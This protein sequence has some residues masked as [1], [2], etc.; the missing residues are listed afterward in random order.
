MRKVLPIFCVAG[1]I[2]AVACGG[3]GSSEFVDPG[4]SGGDP[5][6]SGG[7]FGG[8]SSGGT[9]G[10]SVDGAGFADATDCDA[11]PA[12]CLPPAV[13]GDGKAGLGESC[14]DGNIV[15]G[16][17]CSSTCKIEGP[18]WACVFGSLCIDVRDCGDGGAEAGTDGGCVP[19]PK[20]PACGDG[21]I[22]PGEACD[23]GNLAGG[24]GCAFDCK[25]IEPNFVCPTPGA[26]CQSTVVCGDNKISGSETCDDGNMASNDGC[27]ASCQ[28]ENGWTCPLPGVACVAKQC[29][30]GLVAG[31]EECDDGNAANGDGCSSTCKL[32]TQVVTVAPTTTTPGSTNIVHYVC[33]YPNP[34]L[35]PV[36]QVCTTTVCGNG[37]R[38]GSEQCDDGN[39]SPY[40]G[41]S[42]SCEFEPSCPGGACVAKCGDGLVFP[43][44]ACDDGNTKNGDGCSSAC[45]IE[46]GYQCNVQV[47]PD[48]AFLDIPIVLRDFKHWSSSDPVSHPD[49]E[50]YGCAVASK[51]LVQ[52]ML[53][54]N[55]V[56]VF[57][58]NVAVPANTC[59]TQLTSATDFTDWYRDINITVG[60]T[61]RDRGRRFDD[62]QI[63]LTRNG[64]AGNYSYVFDSRFDEPYATRTGFYPL[65]GKAGTWGNQGQPHNFAFSTELRYWFTYDAAQTPQ[66]DF[67]GDDDVWVFVNGRLALDIGGLHPRVAD[68][69]VLDGAKAAALGL[70]NGSIYEIA[71]FHA[72]RHTNA[73]NFWLTLRGFVKKRSVC[74]NVCGDGI[75]TPEEQ[76]DLGANNKAPGMVPYGGCSTSCTLGPYCGDAITTN[77]PEA[78][79]DGVNM[80]PYTPAQSSTKCA[81][82]CK[83]PAY[84][85]DG[86]VQGSHGEKCDNGGAN[87]DALYGG[88]KTNCT[89][90]PRCGDM[91]V[92]AGN[93]EQCDNG[94]NLTAYVASPGPNDCAPTCKTPRHCGDGVV[95]YPFEQCDQGAGN[96]NSGAY[97]SCKTDCTAGPRCG[98][99]IVQG[100]SGEQCDDGN[101]LNGDG[102][103]AAC[104]LEG[105]GGPN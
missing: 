60:G 57:A 62:V 64:A 18:F 3:S 61:P 79:D 55:G 24:D 25:T 56:P 78:C 36:R 10:G 54:A 84:C 37:V 58:S 89:P 16:D 11:D 19:P 70:V 85:G 100:G 46:A 39:T 95:D 33:T 74:T 52:N 29:S 4:S 81:P 38:E 77:P 65:D 51:G 8:G 20:T 97:N 82:S 66:L 80:T 1:M 98:D 86:L 92:Q 42:K 35:N 67:S 40:D 28:L 21:M 105:P 104:L 103:S 7:L 12:L 23:D 30:D 99:K 102:C 53:D 90:G 31:S 72:E 17:G 59:G 41:C 47:A 9:D 63:R 83:R 76:C 69:F 94:F 27:S 34:P 6:S 22:D 68:S 91:I 14:D 13:C 44:E 73:S 2:V 87:D 75:K 101:R 26:L 15:G 32:E 88:C 50:R 93:G 48:P 5:G 43:G 71:L 45:Q 49:Y 96:T